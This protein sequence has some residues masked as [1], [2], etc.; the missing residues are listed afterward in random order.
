METRNIARRTRTRPF[1]LN[2]GDPLTLAGLSLLVS[3]TSIAGTD[4]VGK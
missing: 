2:C 1:L 3:M 4:V